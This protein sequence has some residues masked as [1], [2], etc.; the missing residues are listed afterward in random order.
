MANY[1]KFKR[2]LIDDFNKLKIKE[3]DTLYFIYDTD[4]TIAELW[5][6]NKRIASS[7]FLSLTG[8]QDILITEIK[9][10]DLLVYESGKWINKSI[11]EIIDEE[12]ASFYYLNRI[13]LNSTDEIYEYLN[14]P[15]FK[16]YTFMVP[17]NLGTELDKYDEY[18][19]LE[20][21]DGIK[22][23]E[24]VGS[25][26]VDLS[27]YADML[28]SKEDRKKLDESLMITSINTDALSLLNGHLDLVN[29]SGSNQ[30]LSNKVNSI[31]TNIETILNNL[32]KTTD[33]I[34]TLE[35]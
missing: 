12:L 15:N 31:E 8:L 14:E 27:N 25:L 6:G 24:Q 17:S 34:D 19:I 28:V 1:V 18:I 16:Q 4:E 13:I 22:S 11:E 30:E 2:G 32:S 3:P 21:S 20:S 9:D 33:R 5:L 23:I 10:K 29:K 7:S 26:K 35:D